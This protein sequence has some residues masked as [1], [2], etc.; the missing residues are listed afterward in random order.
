MEARRAADDP[1]IVFDRIALEHDGMSR[2]D[3]DRDADPGQP[4][5]LASGA[6]DNCIRPAREMVI[7]NG[8][9]ACHGSPAPP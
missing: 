7:L 6:C 5:E 4:V 8:E 3:R 2:L 9:T 1:V